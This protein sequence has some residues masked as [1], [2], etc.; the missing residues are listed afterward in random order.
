LN[1][2]WVV[3]SNN[4]AGIKKDHRLMKLSPINDG[5]DLVA[6]ILI[7]FGVFLRTEVPEAAAFGVH[8]RTG[9]IGLD[10]F[11]DHFA[12]RFACECCLGLQGSIDFFIDVSNGCVH[13][14]LCNASVLSVQ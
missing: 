3:V 11:V 8:V 10:C 7:A 4:E 2:L 12:N 5:I 6:Q 9:Q 14:V 1:E 13:S